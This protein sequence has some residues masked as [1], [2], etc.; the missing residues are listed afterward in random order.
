MQSERQQ[1]IVQKAMDIIS[2]DGLQGLTT[3][4]LAKQLG[5]SEPALYRH[6]E[7]KVAILSG[8]LEYFQKNTETLFSK[9]VTEDMTPFEKIATFFRNNFY[10]FTE[11]PSFVV[12]IFSDELYRNEHSLNATITL[13]RHANRKRLLSIL[14]SGQQSGNIRSDVLKEHLALI[15]MSTLRNFVSNW[16]LAGRQ[17]SLI[18]SG[19]ELLSALGKLLESP[20]IQTD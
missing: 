13:I 9:S 5:L 18:A 3:K 16:Q 2:E 12:V 1:Q 6:F 4:N 14:E 15:L 17:F 7:N 20:S 10:T 19:E 8:V 11:H